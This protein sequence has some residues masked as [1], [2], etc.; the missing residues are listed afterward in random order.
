[1]RHS[2]CF[3]FGL[4]SIYRLTMHVVEFIVMSLTHIDKR[5][6]FNAYSFKFANVPCLILHDIARGIVHAS[7]ENRPI[8]FHETRFNAADWLRK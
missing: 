8:S 7:T 3:A 6:V 1:M 2:Q 5:L 4:G